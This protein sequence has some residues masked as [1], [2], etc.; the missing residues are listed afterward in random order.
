MTEQQLAEQEARVPTY[1]RALLKLVAAD[2]ELFDQSCLDLTA[3][4]TEIRR[5]WAE[6]TRLFAS[7]NKLSDESGDFELKYH[8]ARHKIARLQERITK[9]LAKAEAVCE[10]AENVNAIMLESTVKPVCLSLPFRNL[11]VTLATWQATR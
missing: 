9:R 1:Q 5:C 11:T 10:A 3:C 6:H 7:L 2:F 8:H 4:H